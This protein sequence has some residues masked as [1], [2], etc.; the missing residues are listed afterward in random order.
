LQQIKTEGN[1]KTNWTIF[2]KAT[3]YIFAA[4]MLIGKFALIYIFM[5]SK[6]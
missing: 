2:K 6:Y 3:L 5:L 1:K 4:I